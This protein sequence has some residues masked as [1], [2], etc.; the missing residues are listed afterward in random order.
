MAI[1][2]DEDMIAVWDACGEGNAVMRRLRLVNFHCFAGNQRVG[3]G[4]YLDLTLVPIQAYAAR[5][6]LTLHFAAK[7]GKRPSDSATSR[8]RGGGE[9]GKDEDFTI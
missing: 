7:Q 6:H 2:R 9:G 1:E 4:G 5:Q 8:P 3:K